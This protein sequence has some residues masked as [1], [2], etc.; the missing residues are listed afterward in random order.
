MIGVA[1]SAFF[2]CW[3][4]SRAARWF[5]FRDATGLKRALAP[6]A[7]TL[8]LLMLLEVVGSPTG[9]SNI[10]GA[11]FLY[12]P[13]VVLLSGMDVLIMRMKARTTRRA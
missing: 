6:N 5:L 11:L 1:A 9:T 4:V 10:L 2:I 12:V 8:V 3:V 7:L 13:A